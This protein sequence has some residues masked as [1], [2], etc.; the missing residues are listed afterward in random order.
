M[1][2][3]I[4][5]DRI[6]PVQEDLATPFN[7]F[8]IIHGFE[9][10]IRKDVPLSA[11]DVNLISGEW[12]VI[13]NNGKISRVTTSASINAVMVFAGTE[14][15]DAAA[16]KAVT[17]VF[18]PGVVIR[19]RSF[20]NTGGTYNVGTLL[21]AKDLGSGEA[22][23]TPALAAEAYIGRVTAVGDGYIE[24]ITETGFMPA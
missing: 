13:G 22:V 24:F 5:P 10:M 12:G 14:R 19:T 1:V 9:N 2:Q 23:V 17:A 4:N 6:V 3:A 11:D 15:F 20:Y 21:A 18:S 8:E 16:N 7:D